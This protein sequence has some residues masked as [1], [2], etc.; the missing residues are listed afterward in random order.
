MKFFIAF[1]AIAGLVTTGISSQ[2]SRSDRNCGRP[3]PPP[4]DPIL[5]L[6][7][8]D[9][10]GEISAQELEQSEAVL[11]KLDWDK[12]GKLTREELPRPPRPEDERGHGPQHERGHRP[13]HD[14]G[15]G[16]RPDHERGHEQGR[17]PGDDHHRRP[18]RGRPPRPAPYPGEDRFEGPERTP[19][20]QDAPAGTVLF[21]GG[22]ETDPRDH[23]RPVAL[24]AA[25]LGVEAQVFRDA[26]SNVKPA[27]N[28]HPTEARAR[29][30]KKVLLDALGK[31]GITNER[32]DEVSNYYRYQP[33]RGNLWK[34]TPASATA[35]IKDGKVTE[36][37]ILNPG[38]GY[39]TPPTVT[40]AGYP[41]LRITAILSFGKNLNTNGTIQSLTVED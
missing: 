29:A 27:R 33:G 30:N 23:G 11:K 9:Q 24:I 34:H 6:F 32:L 26:F 4:P 17:R 1:V 38:A 7:D 41:D 36:I 3:G 2:K 16:H 14:R 10:D 15:H 12:D 5:R 21:N 13:E 8:T 37:R 40:I 20:S 25:A 28:G 22:Y 31:H 35:I 19:V 39:L 18:E